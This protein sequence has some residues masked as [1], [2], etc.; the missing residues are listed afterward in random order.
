LAFV[1]KQHGT[2]YACG[3]KGGLPH[4]A[5]E[6]QIGNDKIE[7]VELETAIGGLRFQLFGRKQAV[8]GNNVGMSVVV[9]NHIHFGYT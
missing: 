4:N 1:Q 6:W 9:N 8:C 3:G 5:S 7:T 2:F